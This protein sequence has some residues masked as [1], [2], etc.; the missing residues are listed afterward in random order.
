MNRK[1]LSASA[2]LACLAASA[3]PALAGDWNNGAG[4]I[5][6]RGQAAVPVPAPHLVPDGPSG[7]YLRIDAGLGRES[8]HGAKE[9][10]I[11]YGA[12]NGVDS[13]SAS[14]AGFGSSS[15]WFGNGFDTNA[16]YGAGVGYIWGHSWRTDVTIDRRSST[17]YKMRGTYQYNNNVVNP[18]A[19]FSPLY[20]APVPQTR[21]DGVSNDATE[22]KSGVLMLNSYYDW[23][24]RSAVTPYI[25][26]GI[27]LAYLD[28]DRMHTTSDTS[29][30]TTQVPIPC[31]TRSPH[32]SFSGSGSDTKILWAA[33]AH[34]GFSYA[35]SQVT[36]LDI[37][38]RLLYIP[39]TNMDMTVNGAQSRVTLNDIFEHQLR[40]GLRWNIN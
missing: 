3:L 6:D 14:G 20:I 13:Y 4:S 15:G 38:Y 33:A 34:A 7:W 40:A 23:K 39:G 11:V 12:G 26:L 32:S 37:N 36:S 17:E 35:F 8:N 27:G 9:S 10:G 29:C 16:N 22:L 24:N 31:A 25:G 2:G 5:K 28:L 30:D 1:I 21:I 19:P 18:V